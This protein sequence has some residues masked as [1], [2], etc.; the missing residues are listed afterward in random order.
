MRRAGRRERDQYNA[1]VEQQR[2]ESYKEQMELR[3]K[4]LGGFRN[5]SV[6]SLPPSPAVL[7]EKGSFFDGAK[8]HAT[9]PSRSPRLGPNGAGVRGLEPPSRSLTA[10]PMERSMSPPVLVPEPPRRGFGAERQYS[11][12]YGPR[13]QSPAVGMR[14]PQ[15]FQ[16]F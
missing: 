12:S 14:S 5:S 13:S 9:A 7:S 3:S 1:L 16:P 15:G 6:P 4:G 10:S 8:A 2:A 11:G